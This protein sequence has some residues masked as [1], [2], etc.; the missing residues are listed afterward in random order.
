MKDSRQYLMFAFRRVLRPLI[1]ILVRAGVRFDEFDSLVR[2][3]FVEAAAQD[4][5]GHRGEKPSRAR[6]SIA[7]GIPRS[8]VDRFVETDGALPFVG[9]SFTNTLAKVLNTWHTDNRFLGPY[10]M[11]LELAKGG[12]KGRAFKDL[13]Q[14]VDPKADAAAVLHELRRLGA[15]R[16]TGDSHVRVLSRAMIATE[17]WSPAQMELFG[18]SLTRLANTLQFNID[19]NNSEKRVERSVMA[20]KGLP[21]EMVPVFE[22]MV[23][24]RVQQLLV[25][26]DNWITPHTEQPGPKTPVMGLSVFEFVDGTA[27]DTPRAL[28][29][30]VGPEDVPPFDPVTDLRRRPH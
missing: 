4:G 25:E 21:P 9:E 29:D 11:P 7:T 15:V 24:E 20:E 18:N 13:V 30:M 1:R 8:D 19:P 3:V 17:A 14:S 2:G 22:A 12:D 6:I 10:G 23:R 5:L 27:S 16:D 26:L 28:K